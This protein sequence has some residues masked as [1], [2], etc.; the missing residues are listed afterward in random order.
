MKRVTVIFC[1]MFAIFACNADDVTPRSV[2]RQQAAQASDS[3][4]QENENAHPASKLSDEQR[5]L[6]EEW[7]CLAYSKEELT[8]E[9]VQRMYEIEINPIFKNALET[10]MT[11][12][13]FKNPDP[14]KG[15]ARECPLCTRLRK[16]YARRAKKNNTPNFD[17][18]C[19]APFGAE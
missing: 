16:A 6:M 14:D 1:M 17:G 12:I 7:Y 4:E 19:T 13:D 9:E 2:Q 8:P 3:Q 11:T 18:E 15:T 5:T 10:A